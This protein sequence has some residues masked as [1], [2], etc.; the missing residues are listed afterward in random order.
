MREP[1]LHE[2]GPTLGHGAAG[3]TAELGAHPAPFC[4][5]C[6]CPERGL[7]APIWRL[8]SAL[9]ERGLSHP[10]RELR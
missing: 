10:C 7:E 3:Q 8:G 2:P 1:S 4:L 9:T 6:G 5:A